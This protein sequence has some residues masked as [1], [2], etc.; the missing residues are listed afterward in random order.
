MNYR[1]NEP[2]DDEQELDIKVTQQIKLKQCYL[3]ASFFNYV[4]YFIYL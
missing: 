2:R 3:S 4:S 1:T